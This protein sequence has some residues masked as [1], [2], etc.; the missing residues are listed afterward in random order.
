MRRLAFN[1]E[2]IGAAFWFALGAYVAWLGWG[3]GLGRLSEPGSGAAIFWLGIAIV[4]L[5]AVVLIQALASGAGQHVATLWHGTRWPK[6]VA[7]LIALLVLGTYFEE[8]GFIVLVLGLLLLC[9]FVIDP[10]RWWIAIPV[11]LIATIGVWGVMTEV[12]RIQLPGGIL[13]EPIKLPGGAQ[14][15]AIEPHLRSGFRVF[16][17]HF[18]DVLG[19]IVSAFGF[20]AGKLALLRLW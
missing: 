4:G 3:L 19:A 11:A 20:V 5:G 16:L 2:V 9:M 15:P 6:I 13:V 7:V 10:V 17:K 18:N 1:S 8:V 14:I 12:L